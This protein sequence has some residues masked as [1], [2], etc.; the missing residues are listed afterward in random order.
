MVRLGQRL[1]EVRVHVPG[2]SVGDIG[3][4]SGALGVCLALQSFRR[5][6]A[7]RSHSLVVSAS[8][9]GEVACVVVAGAAS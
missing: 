4:A 7:R 6:W 5:R 1:M 8:D 9:T 3:A 2:V